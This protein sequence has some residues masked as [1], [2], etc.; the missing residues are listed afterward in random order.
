MVQPEAQPNP[1]RAGWE[2]N[3]ILRSFCARSRLGAC[4]Y[5]KL[6]ISAIL[7]QLFVPR[8]I[9]APRE[10]LAGTAS[11]SGRV[12]KETAATRCRDETRCSGCRARA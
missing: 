3:H 4:E 9:Q 10:A 12:R 11:Q 8:R 1:R 6:E 5:E 2:V 7:H